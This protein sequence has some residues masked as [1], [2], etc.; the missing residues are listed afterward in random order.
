[1]K[2]EHTK[3]THELQRMIRQAA[4][5]A[6]IQD[7]LEALGEPA[8]IAALRSLGRSLQRALWNTVDGFRPVRLTDL[9]PE[10]CPELTAVRHF[11]RNTLLLF[12]RFEKRFYR[13]SG[14]DPSA[15]EE[16]G[17]ANFLSIQQLTGP[18][19]FVAREDTVRG[20][21]LV[22][23]TRA[24]TTAPADFMPIVENKRNRSGLVY[25]GMIDTLRG[26]SEHVT[27]GSAA[28][29]GKDIGSWF[30]LCRQAHL[31]GEL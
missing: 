2:S 7:F 29:R 1:M 5:A 13:Y 26:V 18:G 19:Y 8:R 28:K 22:D 23:Y 27:I 16:L 6:A 31:G 14:S 4:A 17:G 9:V 21:V 3:A 12:T 24:P 11:G 10:A 15:P 20:E 30:T 25:G